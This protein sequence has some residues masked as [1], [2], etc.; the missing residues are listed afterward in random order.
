MNILVLSA[1]LPSPR[2]RQAGQKTSYQLCKYLAEKHTIDLLSFATEQ[3]RRW[4]DAQDMIIFRSWE[5]ACVSRASRIVGIVSAPRLP[6]AVGARHARGFR[7]KLRRLLDR[8]SY[9]VAILDHVAM[10]QYSPML[11]SICLLAGSAHDV[12]A[13]LWERRASSLKNSLLRALAEFECRRVVFWE[14]CQLGRLDVVIPHSIKDANLHRLMAPAVPRIPINPWSQVCSDLS[15]KD[16]SSVER[17]PR[18]MVFWGAMDRAENRDAV[19]FAL[20]EIL[21][22]IREKRPDVKFYVAGNGSEKL[23]KIAAEMK[24]VVFTGFLDDP[25]QFLSRMEVALLPLRLGAGIKIKTLECMGSGVP[26]VGTS[27][28][29]E[30]VLGTN[31]EHFLL[32]DTA[33]GLADDVIRLLE[34]PELARNIGW[35]GRSLVLARYD[36]RAP[37]ELLDRFLVEAVQERKLSSCQESPAAVG[38]SVR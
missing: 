5:I 35:C 13:Q 25:V 4:S 12:L 27:V 6:L 11:R 10:W 29:M 26:V 30:G 1:H 24:N 18:S 15:V 32:A 21:P 17:E 34:K 38:M 8:N 33:E 14:T 23:S 19:S 22:L 31:G 36:F 20:S 28:A 3:E 37:L 16:P 9:D 7:Q 2:A